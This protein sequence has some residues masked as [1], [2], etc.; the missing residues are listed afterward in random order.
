MSPSRELSF[1]ETEAAAKGFTQDDDL[2][3]LVVEACDHVEGFE[4]V[5]RL[6]H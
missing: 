2:F 4:A 1:G 3:R 6:G 5:R